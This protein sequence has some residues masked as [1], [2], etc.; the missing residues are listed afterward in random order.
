MEIIENMINTLPNDRIDIYTNHLIIF[1]RNIDFNNISEDLSLFITETLLLLNSSSNEKEEL[2]IQILNLNKK[3]KLH[4]LNIISKKNYKFNF[5]LKFKNIII[6]VPR[7]SNLSALK[8][9]LN[10]LNNRFFS[11]KDF[12]AVRLI[13]NVDPQ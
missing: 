5:S 9:K 7:D 1:L 10:H 11:D 6:K 2:L 12:K 8:S 13:I 3:S 4:F